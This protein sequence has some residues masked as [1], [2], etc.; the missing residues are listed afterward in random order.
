MKFNKIL[1]FVFIFIFVFSFSFYSFAYDNIDYSKINIPSSF[2]SYSVKHFI[3][4]YNSKG[5]LLVL[6]SDGIM[7]I[8]PSSNK[9]FTSGT[10]VGNFHVNPDLTVQKSGFFADSGS[11]WSE[12]QLNYSNY[13]YTNYNVKDLT[14]KVFFSIP[15]RPLVE[16]SVAGFLPNL[17]NQ[18]GGITGVA[19][20]IFGM[21][22]AIVLVPRFLRRWVF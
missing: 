20:V 16:E 18:I 13:K 3:I 21:I 6:L 19:L 8:D 15:P 17:M 14:G 9:I 2:S 4:Y 10:I 1:M 12:G 22:L 7:T 11:S 5:K